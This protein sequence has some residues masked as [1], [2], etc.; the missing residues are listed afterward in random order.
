MDLDSSAR[1]TPPDMVFI[2]DAAR[3]VQGDKIETLLRYADFP[4]AML[5]TA[6]EQV[7]I[8]VHRQ[9]EPGPFEWNLELVDPPP[10]LVPETALLYPIFENHVQADFRNAPGSLT[11]D[12]SP[13][14]YK[15][16]YWKW[17]AP[18]A[19]VPSGEILTGT[20]AAVSFLRYAGRRSDDAGLHVV[21]GGTYYI[22]LSGKGAA[23]FRI[24]FQPTSWNVSLQP[25]GRA[26]D[27]FALS[28]QGPANALL[29]LE[30][31][32]DLLNWEYFDSVLSDGNPVHFNI[33]PTGNHEFFRSVPL[34]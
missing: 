20:N 24:R 2:D 3:H 23:E 27:P 29:L 10:N 12:G 1:G 13:V 18:A 4:N 5:V 11:S 25:A 33:Q 30:S 34:R 9:S 31:S 14:D 26:H 7:Q 15:N 21:A 22:V 16:L 6:G 17:V 8:G 19:S 32:S 28:V